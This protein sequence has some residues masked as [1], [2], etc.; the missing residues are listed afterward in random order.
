[1]G[2]DDFTMKITANKELLQDMYR[3]YLNPFEIEVIGVKDVPIDSF[4]KY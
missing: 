4:S 2:I 3:H 1:M